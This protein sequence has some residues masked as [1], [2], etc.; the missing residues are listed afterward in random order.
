MHNREDGGVPSMEAPLQALSREQRIELA[1]RLAKF[2][3]GML[4]DKDHIASA[5]VDKFKQ[6]LAEIGS[7]IPEREL[8][9]LTRS[10]AF[11][12]SERWYAWVQYELGIQESDLRLALSRLGLDDD[13]QPEDGPE[14]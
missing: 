1:A 8:A 5:E 3:E 11:N 7:T 12:L 9:Y 4:S 2:H 10:L 13:D 6:R 14:E